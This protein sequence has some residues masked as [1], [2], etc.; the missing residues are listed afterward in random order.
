MGP[1][2]GIYLTGRSALDVSRP[3]QRSIRDTAAETEGFGLVAARP[4]RDLAVCVVG[5]ASMVDPMDSS[6]SLACRELAFPDRFK[7]CKFI[8]GKKRSQ[9]ASNRVGYTYRAG[10]AR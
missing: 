8:V 5:V 6:T 7:N 1:R 2:P 3:S 4:K 10:R 9:Q